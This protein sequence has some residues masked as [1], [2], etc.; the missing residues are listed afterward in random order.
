MPPFL[1]TIAV[2]TKSSFEMVNIT[3][4]VNKVVA[5]SKVNQGNLM[6]FTP[7]TT[8]AIT[9]NEDEPGLVA[10]ILRKISELVPKGEGYSHDRIDSNAHAHILASIIGPSVSIP[11]IKGKAALGTWQSILFIELD[12]PRNR[13]IMVQIV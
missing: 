13:R 9:I 6:V 11:I 2:K 7:H 5:K 12:G 1:E 4:H 8:T 3:S 10:D